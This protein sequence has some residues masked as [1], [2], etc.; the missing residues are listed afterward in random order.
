MSS[1]G[2]LLGNPTLD[3][4][5][6]AALTDASSLDVSRAE[7]RVAAANGRAAR[8]AGRPTLDARMDLREGRRRN[9]MTGGVTDDLDPIAA[10]VD[11]SWE[12]GLFGRISSAVNAAEFAE[13]AGEHHLRDRELALA[14]EVAQRYVEGHCFSKHLAIR[15]AAVAA[16]QAIT[17]YLAGRVAAGL[18]RPQ[19]QEAADAARLLAERRVAEAREELGALDAR[20]RYL[21][22]NESIPSVGSIACPLPE[23]LPEVPDGSALHT[24]VLS[25][26]DVQAA[27]AI[28]R[29]A[30]QSTQ[31]EAR[32][33]RPVLT[34]IASVEGEGPSPTENPDEWMAWAGIRLSLPVLAPKAGAALRSRRAEED[35][36]AALYNETVRLG[37]LDIREAF[38]KRV[39]AEKRW[40]AA[41]QE[42]MQ[43]RASL[44][45]A[46]RQYEQGLESITVRE[47]ARLR[48]LHADERRL[49]LHALAL[50]RHIALVRA[51]GG[52]GFDQGG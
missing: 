48:W 15:E 16:N 28:W 38:V 49:R 27:D 50:Q 45:S 20:W 6:H 25:R 9:L 18:M 13:L 41:K 34:A 47:N 11:A 29:G 31:A 12:L 43:L 1:W 26:P 4:W 8:A 46:E 3:D 32:D 39:H 19:E 14:A 7:L 52:P 42:A 21:L 30:E 2:T 5:I 35:V 44:E 40:Q 37:L 10:G 23:P 17:D 51:C 33:R 36:K 24:Y 22:P